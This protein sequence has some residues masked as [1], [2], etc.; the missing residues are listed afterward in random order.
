MKIN[1]IATSLCALSI[2]IE[3]SQAA[4]TRSFKGFY[5]GA[6]GGYN[7]I[8]TKLEGTS[9]VDGSVHFDKKRFHHT[10]QWGGIMGWGYDSN[11]L[12]LGLEAEGM[13]NDADQTLLRDNSYSRESF[14]ARN[15][16]KYGAGV[17]FGFR[18]TYGQIINVLFFGRLAG[19]AEKWT[20]K[21]NIK[22]TGLLSEKYNKSTHIH[23]LNYTPGLGVEVQ[24]GNKF[25]IRGEI[26]H[27]PNFFRKL[28][29]NAFSNQQAIP[30][31][32]DSTERFRITQNS[33]LVSIVYTI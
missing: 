31:Y 13:F 20:F 2:I 5:I 14:H 4:S 17:R 6:T 10:S 23:R 33:I 7:G 19:Q 30:K 18:Q 3:A 16:F 15:K 8:R 29:I 28:H 27:I 25:S 9:N 26:R 12:Y 24:V 32:E 22:D 21:Y 1:R 11:C